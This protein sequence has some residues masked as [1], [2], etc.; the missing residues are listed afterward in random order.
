MVKTAPKCCCIGYTSCYFIFENKKYEKK[1]PICYANRVNVHG[2]NRNGSKRYK[3]L[4]CGKTFTN[5]KRGVDKMLIEK[6]FL[7]KNIYRVLKKQGIDYKKVQKAIDRI[8][9]S[10]PRLI[11]RACTVGID[12]T[13]ID[14]GIVIFKDLNNH[15][16]LHW[17]F[18][19]NENLTTVNKG[20]EYLKAS[21]ITP[22][23][24][25][26]DGTWGFFV[27]YADEVPTQ[28]CL[29]HMKNIVKKYITTKPKLQA[30]K[31]L[32]L[33]IDKLSYIKEK[34]FNT[35]FN[36][37]LMQYN[38]FLNEKTI[39][40]DGSWYYTHSRL[41]KAVNSINRYKPFLFTYQKYNH[42]PS[43]NNSIEGTNSGLKGFLKVHN[44]LRI[45]RKLK[46]AH[47]YLKE[48]SKFEWGVT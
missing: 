43:T 20:I 26:I 19:V 23:G 9:L 5:K 8:D 41:R 40:E 1:C 48:K 21:G 42:I 4:N 10:Y 27:Q 47:Y 24:Y 39:N 7:D 16:V 33:I 22:T 25:V 28:M 2:Y 30:G 45:D 13:Y 36:L 31:D 37:W 38:D 44:G 3:C 15:K 17:I 29:I 14:L 18:T 34:D 35:Q 11:H 46:L 32:K 6:Y 12:T